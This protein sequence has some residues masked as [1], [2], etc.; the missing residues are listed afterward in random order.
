[1]SDKEIK[2]NGCE[3]LERKRP[4]TKPSFKRNF[5]FS[6]L[7]HNEIRVLFKQES[8]PSNL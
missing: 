2:V 3:H 6:K 1:M 5:I 8:L 4:T 7:K